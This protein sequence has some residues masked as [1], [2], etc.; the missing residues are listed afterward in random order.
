MQLIIFGD[1]GDWRTEQ[2]LSKIDLSKLSEATRNRKDLLSSGPI[3]RHVEHVKAE[4]AKMGFVNFR[5]V[6]ERTPPTLT[7]VLEP[8]GA[9][10][11]G[12]ATE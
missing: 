5:I 2:V 1:K 7:E 4:A 10:P 3:V 11:G 9:K 8:F 6:D 12:M